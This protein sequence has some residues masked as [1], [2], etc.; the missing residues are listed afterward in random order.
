MAQSA[1]CRK[2]GREVAPGA[3]C[4]ICGGKLGGPHTLWRVSRR[5]LL[6]WLAWNTP[7]RLILP[8]LAVI[9]L[10]LFGAELFSGPG[11][12]MRFL[13]G[14]KPA[15]LGWMLLG[16]LAAPFV[17]LLLQC[18]ETLEITADKSGVTMRV[19]IPNPTALCVLAHFRSPRR[20]RDESL[21]MEYGLLADERRVAWKDIRR[22]QLWPEKGMFL[23][24]GPRWWLRMAV[25]CD[26]TGWQE[27]SALVTEKLGRKKGAVVPPSL[28]PEAGRTGE[29]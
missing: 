2:C 10:I 1:Y 24:Y 22:V 28:R 4:P 6:S 15:L 17:I 16:V 26:E 12:F 18:R 7:L 29:E 14:Q 13:R 9:G 8:V 19:L 11:G 5:P 3:V 21:R 23:L 27:M 20:V 25:P